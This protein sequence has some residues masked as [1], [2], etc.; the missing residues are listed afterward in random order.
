MPMQMIMMQMMQ[1]FSFVS[2]YEVDPLCK[3]YLKLVANE[4]GATTAGLIAFNPKITNMTWT[5]EWN[6]NSEEDLYKEKVQAKRLT[7]FDW[8]LNQ[9]ESQ[10]GFIYQPGTWPE[11]AKKEQKMFKKWKSDSLICIPVYKS[12]LIGFCFFGQTANNQWS[13][14]E[15][16]ALKQ[17]SNL[18]G[19]GLEKR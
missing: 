19:V 3:K 13:R 18:F 15:L 12:K 8:L 1:E 7:G 16:L 14:S 17:I 4:L 9:F 11:V 6:Q 5:A 10:S 2:K